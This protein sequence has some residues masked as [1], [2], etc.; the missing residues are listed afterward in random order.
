M[1]VEQLP[2]VGWQAEPKDDDKELS[3][4]CPTAA[5]PAGLFQNVVPLSV[6]LIMFINGFH[7]WI[8]PP[9]GGQGVDPTP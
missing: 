3:E 2:W 4:E 5:G 6:I 8:V 9:A 1:V 7:D